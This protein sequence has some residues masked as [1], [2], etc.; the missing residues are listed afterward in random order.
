MKEQ[1]KKKMKRMKE[2]AKNKKNKAVN[3]V[4]FCLNPSC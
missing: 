2:V 4:S 1:V 3:R